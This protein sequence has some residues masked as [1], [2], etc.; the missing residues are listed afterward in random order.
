M[1]HPY[2]GNCQIVASYICRHRCPPRCGAHRLGCGP[3]A[4]FTREVPIVWLASL[5]AVPPLGPSRGHLVRRGAHRAS[6]RSLLPRGRQGCAH[7]FSPVHLFDRENQLFRSGRE[8]GS[9][10]HWQRSAGGTWPSTISTWA[11]QPFHVGRPHLGHVMAVHIP[12]RVSRGGYCRQ[13][14]VR[15]C[16][17]R[18]SFRATWQQAVQQDVGEGGGEA[19]ALAGV[20]EVDTEQAPEPLP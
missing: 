6:P 8:A 9:A 12:H 2:E 7:R 19:L 16:P 17:Y 5:T 18:R 11:P 13:D 10:L 20:V 4:E 15:I 1:L 14:G 3:Q